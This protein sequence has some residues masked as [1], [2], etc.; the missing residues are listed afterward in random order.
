MDRED[1][2]SGGR[3]RKMIVAWRNKTRLSRLEKLEEEVRQ[4]RKELEELRK[5]LSRPQS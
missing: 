4:V 2:G 1:W 5:D 3:F